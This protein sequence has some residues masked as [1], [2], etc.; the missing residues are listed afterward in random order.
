MGLSR[1]P[2][3]YAATQHI[4]SYGYLLSVTHTLKENFP[5]TNYARLQAD[6]GSRHSIAG[7]E[8]SLWIK[9]S[10]TDERTCLG[11]ENNAQRM[12]YIFTKLWSTK[13]MNKEETLNKYITVSSH[14]ISS[15]LFSSSPCPLIHVKADRPPPKKEQ[16]YSRGG[17]PKITNQ[18]SVFCIQSTATLKIFE[19]EENSVFNK[20]K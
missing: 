19:M 7:E 15:H 8:L 9:E 6:R 17:H 14:L 20:Y 3:G 18:Y 11:R 10:P 12:I 5:T 2:E 4:N 16:T 13:N 1:P